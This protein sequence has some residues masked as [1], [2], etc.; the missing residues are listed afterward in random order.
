MKDTDMRLAGIEKG[1]YYPY[2]PDLAEA[3]ASWFIPLR[4]G[5]CGRLLDPCAGEGKPVWSI[6]FS[7]GKDLRQTPR[8]S[9]SYEV[10]PA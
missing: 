8:D 9:S 4:A 3:M 5:T 10:L 1:G 2:P 6:T 7:K